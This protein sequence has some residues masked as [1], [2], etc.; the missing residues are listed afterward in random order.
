MTPFQNPTI[1][2]GDLRIDEPITTLTDLLFIGVCFFAFFKTKH[3]AHHTGPNIYRWFFLLTG[4]STLV[5]ALVGHAFLYHFGIEAKIY[6]WVTGIFGTCL[7]QFG[8]L[9]HT[10]KT[11]GE[12]IFKTLLVICILE[13]ITSVIL[14]F[15]VWSFVVVEVHS[16]FVLVLMVTIL[17]SIHYKKTK[18]ALSLNMIYGVGLAIVA[19]LCHVLKLA[20]S[21]WFNHA[22]LSHIF[23]ALS[24]FMMYRGVAKFKPEKE[25]ER[26]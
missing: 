19:V 5:A 21:V 25:L 9:Y 24:M 2:I 18:S 11:I 1:Y 22:D 17:E 15:V 13:V 12:T 16:A 8:A 26:G 20:Y 3:V 23:M 6:G 14:T 10:R 4:A 7:A